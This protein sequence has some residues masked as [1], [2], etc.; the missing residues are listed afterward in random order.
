LS[1]IVDR[2]GSLSMK[3]LE[4]ALNGAISGVFN[5]VGP[6]GV[7]IM[8]ER[9]WHVLPSILYA[10]S[11]KPD[12][13]PD[14]S[15]SEIRKLESMRKNLIHVVVPLL[16][17]VKVIASRFPPEVIEQKLT[18]QW[19]LDKLGKRH[20]EIVEVIKNEEGGIEWIE[21]EAEIIKKFLLS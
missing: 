13:P 5:A 3:V 7:K 11:K 9:R 1:K 2:I 19:I 14:L 6:K 21:E 10:L 16:Q 20:P 18:G 4:S 8:I 12:Y 15:E 17:M